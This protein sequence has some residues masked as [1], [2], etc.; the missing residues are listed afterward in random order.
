[1][2]IPDGMPGSDSPELPEQPKLDIDGL[3]NQGWTLKDTS[4]YTP[5]TFLKVL[6]VVGEG[7][8]HFLTFATYR[9]KDGIELVR[10][11]TLISPKGKQNCIDK[12]KEINLGN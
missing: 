2:S 9:T 3:L 4:L 12:L 6:D 7:N 10:G 1:M 5:E 8:Y 11:Q